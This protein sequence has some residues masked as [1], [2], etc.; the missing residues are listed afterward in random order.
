MTKFCQKKKYYAG[1]IHMKGDSGDTAKI[2]GTPSCHTYPRHCAYKIKKKTALTRK[3][4]A[5]LQSSFLSSLGQDSH[6]SWSLSLQKWNC[7]YFRNRNY[8]GFCE[9][10]FPIR[11]L[12]ICGMTP[13]TRITTS[14][15]CIQ[16]H[17]CTTVVR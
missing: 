17:S 11:D 3:H 7:T 10:F 1:T 16:S 13:A 5:K 15:C 6:Q 2:Y 4:F 12:W 9:P 8:A 14:N